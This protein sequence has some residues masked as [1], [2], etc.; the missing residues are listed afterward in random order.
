VGAAGFCQVNG[1]P[2]KG[3]RERVKKGDDYTF[4]ENF[5]RKEKAGSIAMPG[6]I[7]TISIFNYEETPASPPAR[8]P[9]GF[10]SYSPGA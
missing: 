1:L 8:L 5:S 7:I 9:P 4:D 3:F 6:N 10:S 2:V